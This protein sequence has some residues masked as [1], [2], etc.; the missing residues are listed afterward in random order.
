MNL[1]KNITLEDFTRSQTASRNG[2]K[3]QFN[4]PPEVIECAKDLCE[5]VIEKLINLF[6]DLKLSSGYRCQKVNSLIGG[7]KSSQHCL[8]QA[9][10]LIIYSKSNIEIAKAVLLTKMIFD[11]MIIEFGT[12]EKPSWIHLSYK[13]S[14]NRNEI[15][16]AEVVNGKTI[17]S[18]L[19]SKDIIGN[20]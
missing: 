2:I 16:R 19:K 17:Y 18:K 7:S 13:K 5:N 6:P 3:E 9:S 1:S 14:N 15:L 12:M 4:P 10:D 20:K 8:G 11:Q